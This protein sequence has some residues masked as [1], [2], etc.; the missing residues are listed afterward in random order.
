MRAPVD[1]AVAQQEGAPVQDGEDLRLEARGQSM[2]L[3][4]R[5]HNV[6]V[7]GITWGE[8]LP[9]NPKP[10]ARRVR[11]IC[12]VRGVGAHDACDIPI[13]GN[14]CILLRRAVR[15][16]WRMLRLG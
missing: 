9:L 16:H 15:A 2:M 1:G 3:V 10:N 14:V 4:D 8:A 13:D 12:M 5:D 11:K 7:Q 6:H